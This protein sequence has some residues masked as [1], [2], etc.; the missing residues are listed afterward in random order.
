MAEAKSSPISTREIVQTESK[1]VSEEETSKS[2]MD[3]KAM[4]EK[5]D[6]LVTDLEII[7][8]EESEC[9]TEDGTA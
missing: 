2:T 8:V 5:Q 3:E 1:G 6:G 4:N 9:I 7:T